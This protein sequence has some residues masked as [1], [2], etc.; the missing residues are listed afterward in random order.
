MPIPMIIG[1]RNY[2]RSRKKTQIVGVIQATRKC[3][4]KEKAV[5]VKVIANSVEEVVVVVVGVAAV[6]VIAITVHRVD[7]RLVVM[8]V[9]HVL[10]RHVRAV[11]HD[12]EKRHL[13]PHLCVVVR[14]HRRVKWIV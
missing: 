4:F 1:I 5:R 8:V 6:T 13:N 9:H 11:V 12:Y 2:W 14:L 3:T 10:V 7:L